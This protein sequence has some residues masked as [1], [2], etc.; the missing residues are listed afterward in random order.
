MRA[1]VE[2]A[3][4]RHSAQP[5]APVITTTVGVASSHGGDPVTIQLLMDRAA[6]AAMR[7]KVQARRNQV[8]VA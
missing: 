4:I 6:G 5:T 3:A 1:A 7:A 2:Q 8:H